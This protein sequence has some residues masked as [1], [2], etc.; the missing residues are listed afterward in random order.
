MLF[1]SVLCNVLFATD[2]TNC[3]RAAKNRFS[4]S[5]RLHSVCAFRSLSRQVCVYGFR[6]GGIHVFRVY[7]P[8][9][10]NPPMFCAC[11]RKCERLCMLLCYTHSFAIFFHSNFRSPSLSLSL[12]FPVLACPF[13]HV[14]VAFLFILIRKEKYNFSMLFVL[15]LVL[16]VLWFNGIEQCFPCCSTSSFFWSFISSTFDQFVA[17]FTIDTKWMALHIICAFLEIKTINMKQCRS[18]VMCHDIGDNTYD[19]CQWNIVKQ[20]QPVDSK[21]YPSQHVH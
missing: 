21:P 19:V 7:T 5:L 10:N 17:F 15:P 8:L 13:H 2:S 14:C 18:W 20:I 9:F 1:T 11:A 4:F 16:L 6:F 3:E 12:F